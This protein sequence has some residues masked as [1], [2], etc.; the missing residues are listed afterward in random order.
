M[1]DDRK[2]VPGG[3]LEPPREDED[4]SIEFVDHEEGT[5]AEGSSRPAESERETGIAEVQGSAEESSSTVAELEQKVVLL[6]ERILRRQADFENYRRRQE[7][8]QDQLRRQ[9]MASA[10]EGLL[11]ALD[12]LDRALDAVRGEVSS[13]HMQGLALVRQRIMDTL[14]KMGLEEIEAQGLPFDPALHEA[15]AIAHQPALPPMTVTAVF[16]KGYT[17]GGK[18]LKPARVEVNGPAEEAQG[19]ADA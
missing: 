5:P 15:V 17:L 7:R 9:A 11:P 10:V 6:E 18:L 14:G 2:V 16:Q 8:E 1:P 19:G 4:I 12:D 3:P 13:D